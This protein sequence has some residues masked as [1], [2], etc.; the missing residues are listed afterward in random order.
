M[1]YGLVYRTEHFLTK[2]VLL[3]LSYESTVENVNISEC[4]M[5]DVHYKNNINLF[6]YDT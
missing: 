6:N 4:K 1:V 3:P 2:G 5:Q